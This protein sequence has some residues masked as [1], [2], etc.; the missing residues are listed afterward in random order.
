MPETPRVS[1]P[2]ELVS[3]PSSSNTTEKFR[4]VTGALLYLYESAVIV[5]ES[6]SASSLNSTATSKPV[7]S[8]SPCISK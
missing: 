6:V 8:A 5:N 4:P 3:V 1:I 2:V 7:M